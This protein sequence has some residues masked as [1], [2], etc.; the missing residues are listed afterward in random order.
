MNLLMFQLWNQVLFL[1]PVQLKSLHQG[2]QVYLQ[3]FLRSHLLIFQHYQVCFQRFFQMPNVGDFFTFI[4]KAV[5]TSNLLQ[6]S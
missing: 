3:N 1:R 2:R 6:L 5:A 4:L